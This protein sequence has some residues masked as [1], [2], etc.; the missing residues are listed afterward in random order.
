MGQQVTA[1]QVLATVDPTAAN[2]ALTEANEQLTVAQDNLAKAQ[3]GPTSQQQAVDND[4]LTSDE[5]AVAD[6]SG[7][8]EHRTGIAARPARPRLHD[9]H[10]GL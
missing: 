7:H 6:G 1:G 10:L 3:N 4:Q 2:L 5:N 8:P 9:V